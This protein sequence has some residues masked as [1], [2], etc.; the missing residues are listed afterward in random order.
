MIFKKTLL[1]TK[2]AICFHAKRIEFAITLKQ[3]FKIL[4]QLKIYPFN[5]SYNAMTFL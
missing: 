4:K 3:V 5:F 1:Q 2:F